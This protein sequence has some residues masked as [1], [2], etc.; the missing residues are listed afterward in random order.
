MKRTVFLCTLCVVLAACE[1]GEPKLT[2]PPFIADGA[3]VA[4]PDNMASSA[5]QMVLTADGRLVLR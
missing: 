1:R 4:G 2:P 5:D 3:M